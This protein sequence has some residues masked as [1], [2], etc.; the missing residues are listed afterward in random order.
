[1]YEKNNPTMARPFPA[2]PDRHFYVPNESIEC[3]RQTA[4][5][6]AVRAEGPVLILGGAGLGKSL[7][8]QIIA[9]DLDSRYDLIML[10]AAQ[11]CSRRA[12]LQNILF[13]LGMPYR[14]LSEGELRLSILDR[15]SPAPGN[16]PEGVLILV[17]EA[18]TLSAKLLEELRLITNFTLNNRPRARLLLI[19]NLRL[20]DTLSSPQLA[21]LNQ[22]LASRCYLRSMT[23][24][25]THEFVLQQLAIAGLSTSAMITADA[26]DAVHSACQGLPRLTNQIM[27]HAMV[28]AAEKKQSPISVS[29]IEDAWADLQQLPAPWQKG[30]TESDSHSN[31]EFGSLDS[32]ETVSESPA[33]HDA[34]AA[35]AKKV[36]QVEDQ[37]VV[38][39]KS[40][41]AAPLPQTQADPIPQINWQLPK[42][43]PERDTV[44]ATKSTFATANSDSEIKGS[45]E[46]ANHVAAT[47]RSQSTHNFFAAFAPE[48]ESSVR[49][50]DAFFENNDDEITKEI[51]YEEP[52]HEVREAFAGS[53]AATAA[54]SESKS[55]LAAIPMPE[56]TTHETVISPWQEYSEQLIFDSIQNSADG[57]IEGYSLDTG[58]PSETAQPATAAQ[59]TNGPLA[60]NTISQAVVP[61][62]QYFDN[63]PTD[64]LLLAFEDEQ[65]QFDSMGVW[66]NDPPLVAAGQDKVA[67]S[68]S[69]LLE[70]QLQES[71][72]T[73]SSGIP[74]VGLSA[75]GSPERSD[76]CNVFGDD[77]DDEI[78]IETHIESL[79]VYSQIAMPT[80]EAPPELR[81]EDI[82]R[83][84]VKATQ[85]AATS[86]ADCASKT[87]GS[88]LTLGRE[89]IGDELE[90]INN[91][92]RSSQSTLEHE[93]STT[94][95]LV[96][97]PED[98][99]FTLQDDWKIET[100]SHAW[101]ADVSSTGIESEIA[102]QAEIEEIVSQ[103]NFSGLTNESYVAEELDR[104]VDQDKPKIP[105][106]SIR[107]SETD[108]V[109][110]MHRAQRK[111]EGNIFSQVAE[112]D[113]DRDML[114]VEEDL[115]VT[116]LAA[117]EATEDKPPTK[118]APYTQLF[119][120]LRR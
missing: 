72:A 22:R 66:E 49:F 65:T 71:Q 115:P 81:Q 93:E 64:E 52:E 58:L 43:A 91:I 83:V 113:D 26:L 12:L 112:F 4:V 11:L 27:D 63:R 37:K 68:H 97:E 102:L 2:T 29:L 40:A 1:M 34:P 69:P 80:A 61:G 32:V 84:S 5:R 17:D 98:P 88:E 14:E 19:G 24:G 51:E 7:L 41:S 85:N 36:D 54:S 18:D 78:S 47:Q 79:Q 96:C 45:T 55:D 119:A 42:F 15:L 82:L 3:A 67:R 101:T 50:G 118:V 108:Q 120:K 74:A 28:L 46:V 99:S 31:V 73:Y 44:V 16:A 76:L 110:L 104:I 75:S 92:L 13:E 53:G 95:E 62:G 38:A 117:S 94:V 77:F 33:V 107:R 35:P 89:E 57:F 39:A 70:S 105:E 116:S 10:H 90:Y 60:A 9:H 30:G 6:A 59:S 20:E 100:T 56:L 25:E 86:E 106:N 21:S 114:M 48:E 109:Y 87:P 23:R 8:A 103:L 111:D